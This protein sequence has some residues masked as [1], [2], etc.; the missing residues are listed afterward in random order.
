MFYYNLERRILIIKFLLISGLAF[1]CAGFL[2]PVFLPEIAGNNLFY[3]FLKL[4]YSRV[5]HQSN[6]ATFYINGNHLLVCARCSGIYL[7][8]FLVLVPLLFMKPKW[9]LSLKPFILLTSPLIIDAFA[10][11]LNIYTYSK[12][13]AFITGLL[14]GSIV[15]IYIFDV[16]INSLY[17][18]KTAYEF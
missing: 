11:R 9:K 1:W 17:R 4:C 14:F 15:I 12:I 10:V 5:C 16:L 3:Q 13:N 8:A 6:D 18:A 7:G 2:L